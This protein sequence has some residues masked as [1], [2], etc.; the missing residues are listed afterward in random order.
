VSVKKKE[1]SKG[2]LETKVFIQI[3]EFFVEFLRGNVE[4]DTCNISI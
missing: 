1:Q 3:R 4:G 2:N